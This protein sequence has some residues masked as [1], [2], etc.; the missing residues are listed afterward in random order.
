MVLDLVNRRIAGTMAHKQ[1][2]KDMSNGGLDNRELAQSSWVFVLERLD[3][4][5]EVSEVSVAQGWLY[6]GGIF[7]GDGALQHLSQKCCHLVHCL[8]GMPGASEIF[9]AWCCHGG[10]VAVVTFEIEFGELGFGE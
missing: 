8:D 3:L 1:L 5:Q 2:V 4:L 7:H 9:L 10:V 6:V